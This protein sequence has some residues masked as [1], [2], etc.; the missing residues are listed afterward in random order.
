MRLIDEV[1]I[2]S[3]RRTR[4]RLKKNKDKKEKAHTLEPEPQFSTLYI[5]TPE[6]LYESFI[7]HLHSSL[8][9]N[10]FLQVL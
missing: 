2:Q 7:H 3:E 5:I 8:R 4:W 6:T 10:E 9:V 1:N